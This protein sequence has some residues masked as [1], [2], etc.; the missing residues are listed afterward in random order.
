MQ[1]NKV[2]GIITA[3]GGSK[4]VPRKNVKDFLGK[5]LLAWSIEV[6]KKAD[7]FD[8][9]ILTTDDKEIAE[10]G[11]KFGINV[12]FMRPVE[13]ALDT[14]SSYDVIKHA[15]EWLKDNEHYET[16]WIILLE[17]SSPGRQAFHIKEVADLI[18]NGVNTDSIIGISETPGHFSYLKQQQRDENGIIA[19]VGDGEILRNLIHRNQDVPK[20]YFINSAIYAFKVSNLFDGNNSLWGDS[21]YGYIMDEKYALDIDTPND[22]FVAEIKMK[23]ILEEKI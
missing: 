22:W 9:F 16:E 5:P 13:L 15:V 11:K 19:R 20:S 10:I 14:S 17:P 4:R 2:L 18:I 21:T 3:R 12:P 7:V 1:K 23:K 6:G 8:R